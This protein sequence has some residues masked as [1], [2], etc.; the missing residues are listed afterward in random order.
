MLS[1]LVSAI[2]FAKGSYVRTSQRSR[3]DRSREGHHLA[4]KQEVWAD[5]EEGIE[6][7]SKKSRKDV[8]GEFYEYESMIMMSRIGR[9]NCKLSDW[10]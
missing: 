4:Q 7:A 3:G 9:G 1:S 8:R 5:V 2:D 10:L 6:E